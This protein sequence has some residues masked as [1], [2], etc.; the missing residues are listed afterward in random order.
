[1]MQIIPIMVA[2]VFMYHFKKMVPFTPSS[3]NMD[4][5]ED[6]SIYDLYLD[7]NMELEET[8][9][10]R[11]S[12]SLG[13]LIQIG[14]EEQPKRLIKLLENF[15][16][17]EGVEKFNLYQVEP[18]LPAELPRSWSLAVVSLTC[19]AIVLPSI[20][21]DIT[22]NLFESV[23]EGLFYTNLV[24]ES[25]CNASSE[26]VNAQMA[27][28]KLWGELDD[29]CMWVERSGYQGKTTMD[30]LGWF[31][32]KAKE[33]LDGEPVHNLPWEFIVMNSMYRIAHSII[34]VTTQEEEAVITED[35][36]FTLLS[37][38]IADILLA[39]YTNIPQLIINKCHQSA[40]ENRKAKA[41][42]EAIAKMLGEMATIISILENRDLPSM[43]PHK[44]P[45]I[46]QW[47]C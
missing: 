11:I 38:M 39:C 22:D 44:R 20:D 24:E 32:N 41:G 29:N 46:D 13:S 2:S 15:V 27:A 33:I 42:V 26:L 31:S 9:M 35:H 8:S 37:R 19:I 6:I 4:T 1:M 40:Q 45:F 3:T 14:K 47:R 10:K 23:A 43:E 28:R 12:D 18:L 25:L 36:L 17:F 7:E 21:R 30:I 34:M 16:G 5:Y